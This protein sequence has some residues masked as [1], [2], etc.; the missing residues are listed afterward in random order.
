MRLQTDVE[1]GLRIL[2]QRHLQLKGFPPTMY[3]NFRVTLYPPSDMFLKRRL[4]T[5]EQRLRIVQAA[6]GLMLFSDEYIYHTYFNLSDKEIADIKEQLKKEQEELA[7]QQAEMAPP[8]MAGGMAP[9]GM[10]PPGM[11]E[12]L[13]PG[14]GGEVPPVAP[15][16][17]GQAPPPGAPQPPPQ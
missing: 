12:N 14:E 3:N 5:D 8:P 7:K 13:P 10:A 6:K 15:D 9:P 2:C 11:A 4:E 1:S 17:G 16:A